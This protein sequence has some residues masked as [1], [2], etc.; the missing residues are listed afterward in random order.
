VQIHL[1]VVDIDAERI[2]EWKHFPTTDR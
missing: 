2:R 1:I